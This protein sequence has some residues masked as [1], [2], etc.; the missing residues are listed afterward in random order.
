MKKLYLLLLLGIC[1]P[2]AAEM[3]STISYNPSRLGQYSSLKIANSAAFLGGLST[4]SLDINSATT[5]TN[6]TLDNFSFGLIQ[7][8]ESTIDMENVVF[9]NSSNWSSATDASNESFAAFG[10]STATVKGG[11]ATFRADSFINE[12]RGNNLLLKVNKLNTSNT[13]TINGE[14][15]QKLSV[16]SRDTRGL[17]LAGND[18]PVISTNTV[19]D[20]NGDG[21]P[22]GKNVVLT[23]K[24]ACSLKWV[25]R[26]TNDG[27]EVY[28][29]ALG[30]L[31]H[32]EIELPTGCLNPTGSV[33]A[34]YTSLC[35][36]VLGTDYRGTVT[37]TCTKVTAGRYTWEENTSACIKRLDP[38]PIEEEEEG[39]ITC[40]TGFSWKTS[41]SGPSYEASWRN[42]G[43]T[44]DMK[45][46]GST[47]YIGCAAGKEC[48]CE[49]GK[50]YVWYD[51]YGCRRDSEKPN[52][53][54]SYTSKIGWYCARCGKVTSLSKCASTP[55]NM[56]GKACSTGGTQSGNEII[57]LSGH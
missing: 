13:L 15:G 22:S 28:V 30:D 21:T 46:D 51:T 29:L 53:N 7:G 25:K 19:I 33:G 24:A 37:Y 52:Q 44:M 26:K 34:T 49:P 50:L 54:E 47:Q 27:Q 57:D 39:N 35:S 2:A 11:V 14:G 16:G 40:L 1:M 32:P 8:G 5:M 43:R 4:G 6:Q 36:Q 38:D 17:F 31:C 10:S 23:N 18:I 48:N 56:N 3:V 9:H 55:K 42:N 12:L 41:G 20:Y 45:C